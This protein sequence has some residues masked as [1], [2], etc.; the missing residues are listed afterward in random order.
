MAPVTRGRLTP[1]RRGEKVLRA[2]RPNI[3]LE[4]E[5]R[6]ALTKQIDALHRSVLYWTKAAYNQNEPTIVAL[7]Q[8]ETPAAALLRA[9][10]GLRKRWLKR[11][12]V[13]S[14][15]LAE[16]FATAVKDRSDAALKKIL[17]DGGFA[18]EWRMT[19]AMRDVMGA[20][21]GEQV[22]LIKTIP[23]R[24]F[25][26]IEG[27]VMRSVS[28]GRDLKQLTDDI[29]KI[30]DVTRKR[31]AFIARDQSNK[32]TATMTRTR[33]LET[34]GAEAEAQWLHSGGGKVPRPSHLKAGKDKVRYKVS[35]GW[36][37]PAIN[38]RIW[39]G[40]EINCRCAGKM[41]VPGFS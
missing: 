24:Y 31:A 26:Q 18:V 27:A 23:A 15:K 12:D 3:G 28:T 21:V 37:D 33:Q 35:D 1:K 5:F 16:Y 19:P 22:G 38:K 41:I 36:L 39:P 40:T 8:D 4:T 34:F 7:A 29:E 13:A 32:A 14:V 30:G 2:V 9:I 20:T 10:R 6:R 17:K 25:D 11:F